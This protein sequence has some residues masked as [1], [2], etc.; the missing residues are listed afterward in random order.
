MMS[1]GFPPA[2]EHVKAGKLT[3]LGLT[4]KERLAVAPAIP[5]S[6]ESPRLEKYDFP[7]WVGLFTPAGTLASVLDRLHSETGAPPAASKR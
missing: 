2:F 5:A 1:A 3:P 4:A 7:V 6:S